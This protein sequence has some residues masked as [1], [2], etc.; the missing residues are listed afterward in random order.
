MKTTVLLI[1][2]VVVLACWGQ[3][4]NIGALVVIIPFFAGMI[5]GMM[6]K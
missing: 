4:E 1:A 3:K 6:D 5:V 2:V